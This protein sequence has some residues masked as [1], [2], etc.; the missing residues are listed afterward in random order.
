MKRLLLLLFLCLFTLSCSKTPFSETSWERYDESEEIKE[1]QKNPSVRL[2]FK[3]L[4]SKVRERNEIWANAIPQLKGFSTLEYETL[5]PLVLDKSIP[6]LQKLIRQ[7]RLS[8]KKLT[9]WYLYR[10]VLYESSRDTYLNAILSINPNAVKEAQRLDKKNNSSKSA[11]H[12]MPILLKDNIGATPLAT[13]AGALALKDNFSPDAFITSKLRENGAIILGKTNLSE[14]ANFI[15]DVCP[16]GQSVFGGQTLNPYGRK[17]IDTGGS[18]SG[19]GAA[20]AANF[21][22]AAVGTETSGSILSPSSANSL[23]GLKPTVG[24]LSRSGIVPISSTLDTPGPM[25]KSVVDAAILLDAML[26]KD[27]DDNSSIEHKRWDIDILENQSLEGKKLG[28]IKSFRSDSLYQQSISKL[29]ELG[30]QVFEIDPPAPEIP[31]FLQLL[32][33]DMLRDIPAYLSKNSP[34]ALGLKDM[35]DLYDLHARDSIYIPYGQA[36]FKGVV[37]DKTSDQELEQIRI[38]LKK[39]GQNYFSSPMDSLGLDAVL[40][41]N[42]YS[43]GL[44]AIAHYPALTVPMGYKMEGTPMGLTFIAKSFQEKLLLQLAYAFESSTALRKSPQNYRD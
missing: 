14:W 32:N 43:A 15:C 1:S 17:T 28:Y 16:N 39:K 7:G 2:R 5:K 13:T 37:T 34:A 11:I 41:I 35:H 10:I 31:T 9:Q 40:S 3:Q 27:V 24:V 33:A 8:Y 30:A 36:R 18:S 22:V 20:I 6:E 26:G 29:K 21:A 25:A 44:A 4:Q 19:S 38:D 42:N 12:G 23:V